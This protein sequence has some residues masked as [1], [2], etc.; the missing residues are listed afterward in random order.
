MDDTEAL[1]KR[2]EELEAANKAANE[3]GQRLVGIIQ[4]MATM[5]AKVSG[6]AFA[7]IGQ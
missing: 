7:A 2:I 5:L 4:R 6:E 1:K 3:A